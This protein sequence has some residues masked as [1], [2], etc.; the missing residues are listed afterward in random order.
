MSQK[1]QDRYRFDPSTAKLQCKIKTLTALPSCGL[2]DVQLYAFLDPL[3]S[4]LLSFRFS[5]AVPWL[6]SRMWLEML[7]SQENTAS[8]STSA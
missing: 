8:A 5:N 4:A 7:F 6:A 3:V 1:R 2:L